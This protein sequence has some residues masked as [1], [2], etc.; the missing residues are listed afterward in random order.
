MSCVIGYTGIVMN[1]I[2]GGDIS[3]LLDPDFQGVCL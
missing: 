3:T 2:R 1:L